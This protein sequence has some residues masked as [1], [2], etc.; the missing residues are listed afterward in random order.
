MQICFHITPGLVHGS[1]AVFSSVH[2]MQHPFVGMI[3]LDLDLF[4]KLPGFRLFVYSQCDFGCPPFLICS[5]FSTHTRGSSTKLICSSN[6]CISST[7]P[8]RH[9]LHPKLFIFRL[10]PAPVFYI[11]LPPVHCIAAY[12][13]VW[14]CH[15]HSNNEHHW[16]Y[17][18]VTGCPTIALQFLILHRCCLF[19]NHHHIQLS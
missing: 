18:C 12:N 7:L 19:S 8:L 14:Y 13:C 1:F 5:C 6:R 10:H 9:Q 4:N 16:L 17:L 15:C 2:I 11:T 3:S